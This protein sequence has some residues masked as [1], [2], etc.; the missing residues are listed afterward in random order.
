MKRQQRCRKIAAIFGSTFALPLVLLAQAQPTASP[1]LDSIT[2]DWTVY[3]QAVGKTVS[4]KLHLE[5]NG[6]RLTGTIETSHTG[7]GKVQDGKWSNNKLT[8]TLVF[9][10]HE[11]IKF[12]GE[13]KS[14]G[15]L[16]GQ[17]RTEGRI[18]TWR[19]ERR[20]VSASPAP[21]G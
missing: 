7:P 5:V 21:S 13:S 1:A 10:T 14:D 20:P 17:Y 4:G 11:S 18:D 6:E 9:E 12:D 3:F 19:A 16:A 2:G 15:T 8:A